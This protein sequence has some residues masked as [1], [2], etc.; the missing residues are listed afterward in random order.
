MNRA[1]REQRLERA[2][3]TRNLFASSV[4]VDMRTT[5]ELFPADLHR[6]DHEASRREFFYLDDHIRNRE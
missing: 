4:E 3:V 5:M 1:Q 6:K 2:V